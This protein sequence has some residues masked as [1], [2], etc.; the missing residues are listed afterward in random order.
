VEGDLLIRKA[1]IPAAGL[2]T[3]LLPATKETPKEMLPIF[4]MSGNGGICVKPLLQAVFEQLFDFG[5]REFCFVVGGGKGSI[6][7]H[8]AS[9]KNFVRFLIEGGRPELAEEL[10]SFYEKVNASSLVFVSQPKPG[11]FGDA[12]LRT[13]PYIRES[14]LVQAG[15][16]LILSKQNNH[17]L[18]LFRAHEEF[19]SAATFF[20]QEVEDPRP[21]GV[22]EG[23]EVER[24]IY[25]VER[26]VEKPEKPPSNLAITALY[27]FTPEIFKSLRSISV[28]VGGEL[29]LTDGMQ[30]LME[31]GFKVTAVKL[32]RDELWLDI[33]NPTSYWDALKKSYYNFNTNGHTVSEKK[34]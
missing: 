6:P 11:G 32:D 33:G 30:R 9:D 12:V 7:E 29:Q 21:F 3:R 10:L 31:S 28:G 22:I 34:I 25:D 18:R 24:G 13:E 2:G 20:V 4:A 15:D 14:F 5:L 23:E 8:F 16:T 17:I 26:V 27:L 1:V 19:E